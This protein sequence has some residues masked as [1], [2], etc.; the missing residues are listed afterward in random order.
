MTDTAT[1]TKENTMST[2]KTAKKTKAKKNGNGL[3]KLAK[4]DRGPA[5]SVQETFRATPDEHN[6]LVA[7]ATKAGFG[8]MSDFYR[9]KLGLNA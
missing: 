4:L 2:E 1:E 3:A 9:E 7:A 6:A 5:R 8:S